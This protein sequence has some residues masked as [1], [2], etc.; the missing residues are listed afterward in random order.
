M[1]ILGEELH[2]RR[3]ASLILR[4]P[5]LVFRDMAGTLHRSSS[6]EER[7]VWE[8]PSMDQCQSSEK[9]L[10]NFQ[11]HWST[12][13]SLKTRQRGH[14]SIRI[15]PEIHMDHWLPNLSESSGLHRH[16]SIECSSLHVGFTKDSPF[17]NVFFLTFLW[18]FQRFLVQPPYVE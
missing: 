10:K 15:S 6:R 14:W 7:H 17:R 16:R 8:E 18:R 2:F 4:I 1:S 13:I 9:L 12:R 11:R 3:Q 5:V